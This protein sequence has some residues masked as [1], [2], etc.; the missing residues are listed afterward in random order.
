VDDERTKQFIDAVAPRRKGRPRI[1]DGRDTQSLELPT[2]ARVIAVFWC[3]LLGPGATIVALA[4]GLPIR[5]GEL[6]ALALVIAFAVSGFT[7]ALAMLRYRRWGHR[8]FTVLHLALAVCA[9]GAMLFALVV[10]T[11]VSGVLIAG[12]FV[13]VLYALFAY[14]FLS[15]VAVTK[16]TLARQSHL[17]ATR[18]AQSQG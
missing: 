12:G 13:A 5:P 4:D 7:F 11:F 9:V 14:A 6:A 17:D 3:V 1:R 10:P 15:D 8:G 18:P 16:A 2:S